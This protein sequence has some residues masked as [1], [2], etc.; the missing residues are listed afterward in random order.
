[1]ESIYN[2]FVTPSTTDDANN[3]I[4]HMHEKHIETW[5]LVLTVHLV[6]VKFSFTDIKNSFVTQA[7]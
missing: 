7:Y 6:G 4:K 3:R 1:M 5:S 2:F